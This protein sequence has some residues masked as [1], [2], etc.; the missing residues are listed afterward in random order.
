MPWC[1]VQ[2]VKLIPSSWM[3]KLSILKAEKKTKQIMLFRIFVVLKI[4]FFY[5]I[6]CKQLSSFFFPIA[7]YRQFSFLLFIFLLFFG[8]YLSKSGWLTTPGHYQVILA[9]L[10][11]MLILWI[12]PA[13]QHIG[14]GLQV[15][16]QCLECGKSPNSI[17]IVVLNLILNTSCFLWELFLLYLI[18]LYK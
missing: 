10:V 16:L 1:Y 13:C 18:F 15:T 2:K 8:W 11:K 12:F 6:Q 14:N 7:M 4:T 17:V 5:I 3:V 9:T